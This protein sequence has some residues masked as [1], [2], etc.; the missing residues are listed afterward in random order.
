MTILSAHC[1]LWN[2][3]RSNLLRKWIRQQRLKDVCHSPS[4]R[5]TLWMADL[6]CKQIKLSKLFPQMFNFKMPQQGF[7]WLSGRALTCNLEG[8]RIKSGPTRPSPTHPSRTTLCPVSNL[9]T[10]QHPS[11]FSVFQQRHQ[12]SLSSERNHQIT[13]THPEARVPSS[14][15]PWSLSKASVTLIT[16]ASSMLLCRLV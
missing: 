5:Q 2:E 8:C 11:V 7:W 12:R 15:A 13:A 9:F 4:A 6:W 14:T 1:N 3:N 10:S 16:P